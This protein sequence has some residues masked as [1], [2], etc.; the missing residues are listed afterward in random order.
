MG[1]YARDYILG[2]FAAS[3]AAGFFARMHI[4]M[5]KKKN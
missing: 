5:L 1:K 3:L 4:D 2:N